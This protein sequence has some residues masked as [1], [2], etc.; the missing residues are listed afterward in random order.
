[1]QWAGAELNRRHTDFQSVAL[2]TELPTQRAGDSLYHTFSSCQA[3]GWH[4]ITLPHL[5]NSLPEKLDAQRIS[6][7]SAIFI[8]FHRSDDGESDCH[9]KQC[10]CARDTNNKTNNCDTEY[11]TRYTVD[12]GTDDPVQHDFAMPVNLRTLVFGDCPQHAFASVPS[13]SVFPFGAFS[14]DFV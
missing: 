4:T 8:G 5:R 1:M 10:Y 9:N 14:R 13:G 6:P 12:E 3:Q 11:R 2:P 7:S